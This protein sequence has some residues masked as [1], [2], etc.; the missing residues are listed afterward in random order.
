MARVRSLAFYGLLTTWVGA[1]SEKLCKGGFNGSAELDLNRWRVIST[2]DVAEARKLKQYGSY[3]FNVSDGIETFKANFAMVEGVPW[4]H[5]VGRDKYQECHD[6]VRLR[7][8]DVVVATYPKSGTT[9]V[10]QIVLLL[11]H[12][13]SLA[14]KLSPQTRN[15]F[16][17]KTGMGKVWLEPMLAGPRSGS[18][19]TIDAFNRIASPRVI[20]SHAPYDMLMGIER[21][22]TSP[23]SMQPL[24]TSGAK[25]IYV[26]RNAKDAALSLYYQRAPVSS[27]PQAKHHERVKR[28]RRRQ[29]PKG[30]RTVSR[31]RL[32]SPSIATRRGRVPEGD[33]RDQKQRQMDSGSQ[34]FLAPLRSKATLDHKLRRMPMD[35]WCALYLGGTMSCGSYFDH[36]AQ[37]HAA[38]RASKTNAIL[39]LTYEDI[40]RDSVAAI[41]RIAAHLGLE[42]TDKEIAAVDRASSFEAMRAQVTSSSRRGQGS[43]FNRFDIPPGT[44]LTR[45]IQRNASSGHFRQGMSGSWRASFNARLS[46][47][48]DAMFKTEMNAAIERAGLAFDVAPVW[49]NFDFGCGM[50]G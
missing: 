40:K 18:G 39:F 42:R 30:A 22:Q 32:L 37:W 17:K 11:L 6:N 44:P 45:V 36:V 43:T 29:Q 27:L 31:R 3:S 20:K 1:A 23:I 24:D 4:P 16:S 47:Q 5:A 14:H 10:E 34:S 15:A 12:G 49:L 8:R 50:S 35:A 48:F 13:S 28:K 19:F 46:Q 9:W 41:K 33:R 2:P 38:S 21:P 7:P 25:V 26:A